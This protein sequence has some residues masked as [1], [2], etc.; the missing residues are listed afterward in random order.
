MRWVEFIDG[1][2][3]AAI[4]SATSWIKAKSSQHG[5]KD[6]PTLLAQL[7][8]LCESVKREVLRCQ[9]RIYAVPKPIRKL[10][11]G[12]EDGKGNLMLFKMNE[13]AN[14]FSKYSTVC[15]RYIS[16]CWRAYML[17]REEARTSLGMRFTDEQ[18]GLMCDMGHALWVMDGGDGG[19]SSGE[20]SDGY[21]SDIDDY[22]LS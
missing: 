6:D 12:I 18:W 8:M 19:F 5:P 7:T 10:L 20:S 11:Y 17:G 21:D 3:R 13:G 14:T 9:L 15:Q 4:A 16:F 22:R 2:D 1:K